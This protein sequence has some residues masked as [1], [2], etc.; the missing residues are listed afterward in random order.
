MISGI[1]IGI[2]CVLVLMTA[3][4]GVFVLLSSPDQLI[5][6]AKRS[7]FGRIL[8]FPE[9]GKALWKILIGFYRFLGVL[10]LSVS[11]FIIVMLIVQLT[12]GQ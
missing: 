1:F 3:A 12:R 11:V 8:P 2:A 4:W 5:N 6:T 10:G 7:P 9:E